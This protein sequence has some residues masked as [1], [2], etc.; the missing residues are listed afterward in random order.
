MEVRKKIWSQGTTRHSYLYQ[1]QYT[2]SKRRKWRIS[3]LSKSR[4]WFALVRKLASEVEKNTQ[5]YDLLNCLVSLLPSLRNS[6]CSSC[7][8]Y[9]ELIHGL[10]C[11]HS[12]WKTRTNSR[13]RAT[14]RVDTRMPQIYPPLSYVH[15][16]ADSF[17]YMKQAIRFSMNSNGPGRHKSFTHIEN[18]TGAVGREGLVN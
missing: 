11:T 4:G 8:I 18:R 12:L 2:H 5:G 9:L 14:L 7:D 1:E 17:S 3:I 15:Y 16:I 10:I 6:Q 13:L